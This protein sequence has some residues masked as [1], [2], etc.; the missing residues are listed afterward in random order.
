MKKT[1]KIRLR[2]RQS[3]QVQTSEARLR[4]L[5]VRCSPGEYQ[6]I[7]R[8]ANEAGLAIG[9]YLRSLALGS[10]G[11]RAV[12]RPFVDRVALARLLGEIG[13]LGS[14][15]NQIARLANRSRQPP[16]GRELPLMQADIAAMRTA[17]LRAL[18]REA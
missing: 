10:P 3:V 18:E 8:S 11:P 9:G 13:K 14:N 17:L 4:I 1:A 7:E 16:R 12:R 5:S 15:V 6:L 2:K